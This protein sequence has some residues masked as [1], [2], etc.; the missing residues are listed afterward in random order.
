MKVAVIGAAGRMGRQVCAAVEGAP[1]MT[2]VARIDLG[3][4]LERGLSEAEV[5]VVFSVPDVVQEHVLACV[6]Q[7]VHAVVG[8][9]G[10]TDERLTRVE[11]ALDGAA[12]VG[13]L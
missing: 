13:V 1:D 11:A 8:T 10:W 5:A 9:T 3:D 6:R 7:G 2:L 4:D 12:E